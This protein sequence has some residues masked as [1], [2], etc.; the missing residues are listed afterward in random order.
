[1]ANIHKYALALFLLIL[2]IFV[3]SL[4]YIFLSNP[5]I[6]PKLNTSGLVTDAE[7]PRRLNVSEVIPESLRSWNWHYLDIP[8]DGDYPLVLLRNGIKFIKPVEEGNAL[9]GWK[10]QVLNVSDKDLYVTIKYEILDSD[11]IELGSSSRSSWVRAE[12][13][14]TIQN[15]IVVPSDDVERIG[16]SRWKILS[17]QPTYKLSDVKENGNRFERAAKILNEKR[18]IWVEDYLTYRTQKPNPFLTLVSGKWGIIRDELGIKED[19]RIGEIFTILKIDSYNLPPWNRI[20]SLASYK[21]LSKEDKSSLKKWLRLEKEYG[22]YD[23]IKGSVFFRFKPEDD[24]E[25]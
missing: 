7:I 9:M 22:S 21:S 2:S 4:I 10:Y 13:Y 3:A 6:N 17:I 24:F 20:K 25:D 8:T 23:P 12:N 14:N 5:K 15:T 19:E 18:P 1:M 16:K 11:G